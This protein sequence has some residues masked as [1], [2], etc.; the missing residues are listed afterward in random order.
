MKSD[1]KSL[2]SLL[3]LCL[4]LLALHLPSVQGFSNG[5]SL[6][7]RLSTFHSSD[8]SQ[9]RRY[10]TGARLFQS[11][12]DDDDDENLSL[13]NRFW[14]PVIDDPMLPLT[15][16]GLVQ[17]VGP[18]LQ[19]FWLVSRNSPYPSWATPMYDYTFSPE[20]AFLAPT[21]IHG[22]GLAICWTMG[23][24]AAQAYETKNFRVDDSLPKE[25]EYT[26][27]TW[28]TIKAGAFA[29]GILILATQADLYQEFGRFVQAGESKETDI[30]IYRAVVELINDIFFEFATLVPWRLFRSNFD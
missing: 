26:R 19:L 9:S 11:P 8:S 21:L 18:T 30:R 1:R 20:G 12:N 29:C 10:P 6:S 15:E 4:W 25:E 3:S 17:V 24:L 23:C 2:I 5:P 22:A 14:N 28:N 7:V 27:I 13:V 16:A